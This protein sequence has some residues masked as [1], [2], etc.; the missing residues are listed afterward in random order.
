MWSKY[1]ILGYLSALLS[2]FLFGWNLA[3]L[4]LPSYYIKCWIQA[5]TDTSGKNETIL[6][7]CATDQTDNDFIT[8][9]TNLKFAWIS[10]IFCIGGMIGALSGGPISDKLGRRIG[11]IVIFNVYLISS[12]VLYIST[13]NGVD[14]WQVLFLGRILIGISAGASTTVST[15]YLTEIAPP[16]KESFFGVSFNLGIVCGSTFAQLFGL[17]YFLGTNDN[18]PFLF[19]VELALAGIGLIF[20]LF[21]V[22]SPVYLY[23][24]K[25]DSSKGELTN[26]KLYGHGNISVLENRVSGQNIEKEV[27]TSNIFSKFKGIFQQK[28][29]T[30][31]LLIGIH[32][33]MSQQFCGVNAFIFYSFDILSQAGFSNDEASISAVVLASVLIIGTFLAMVL[34][35]KYGRA[36][37]MVIPML[38]LGICCILFSILT[39]ITEGMSSK[40]L[41][42]QSSWLLPLL[43]ISIFF[44]CLYNIAFAAGPGAIPWMFIP[45][46]TTSDYVDILQSICCL[47][48]WLCQFLVGL[49]FPIV[50]EAIGSYVFLIFGIYCVV[51]SVVIYFYM[52]ETKGKSTYEVQE[53]M[54]RSGVIDR[55][56]KDLFKTE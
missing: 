47:V 36:T 13:I 25:N 43:Y 23:E 11:L 1:L 27:S 32:L 48:N 54:K 29:I 35:K 6:S 10:S 28:N 55:S 3:V 42:E 17:S 20:I 4:N 22:E 31:T 44:I 16:K 18:W 45:E 38:I 51:S 5:I 37:L 26:E 24:I 8:S 7:Y 49:I 2:G 34:I 30:M 9:A 50:N 19:I 21:G 12:L 53:E 52:P 39:V 40:P 46:A 33:M 41:D 14:S 56:I 15:V